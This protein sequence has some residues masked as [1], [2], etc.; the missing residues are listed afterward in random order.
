MKKKLVISLICTCIVQLSVIA[1]PNVDAGIRNQAGTMNVHDLNTLKKYKLEQQTTKDYKRF[2]EQKEKEELLKEEEKEQKQSK[3]NKKVIKARAEEYA[4][5]GVYVEN[6][7]V[8]PSEILTTDEIENI[9]SGY[10]ETNITFE[11]L[12]KI[13]DEINKLYFK[14]GFVTASAYIPEQTI[15]N[16]L[17]K[18]T[19]AE[20]RVGNISITD[21]KW[22]RKKYINDRLNIKE[23][24]IF[25]IS[26]LE[27]SL[28]LFNRYNDNVKLKG[29]LVPGEEKLLTTDVKI[30]AIEKSPFHLM[31]LMDNAGRTT[32]GKYRGGFILQND[33]LFGMRDKLTLGTYVN[34]YSVTPFADYNIPVN[35]KDGRIG[36]SFSSGYTKIGHG[37]FKMFNIRS[38]SYNY[39]L[40]FTQPIIRKPWMEL[41]STSSLNYKQ[42]ST[43]FDGYDLYTDKIS[44]AQTGLSFRYDT[45]RG[46]WYLNQNVS[47]AAPLFQ[48]QS[49]Y[50]KIDGN[51]LRLHDFGHGVVG[52]IRG[53]YQVIPKDV[54]PYLDQF[55]AGGL[56]TVRGYSEG[57][58][59]GR[60]G[61]LVSS[62]ILFPIAP[63]TIK[64]KDK[65]KEIPFLGN[66]L[67]G[68][69]F[70]DHAGVFPYKGTGLGSQGY[71]YNDFL[72]SVGMG[73]R[74]S[75]PGNISLRLAW[76][77]PLMRN[78][79]E[80]VNKL[81]RF[82]FEMCITPDF[83]A[84]VKL[85]RPKKGIENVKNDDIKLAQSTPAQKKAT[86]IKSLK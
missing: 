6:I 48:K 25:N 30:Q 13:I 67:K 73:L 45:A 58:L 34:K 65:T 4:T 63:R 7:E 40:Y 14:N 10:K 82:H 20:G 76:G 81:G 38:R 26:K 27:E 35:K 33:S 42:A 28:V 15:E 12:K 50:V 72:I 79:Y 49:N 75:L 31:C 84:M 85:R 44:S 62:E 23:G 11:Q 21:N 37:P 71:N 2:Q 56:A 36:A 3:K 59:I 55:L 60:N 19:L 68:F 9:L 78:K 1:V 29:N 24:E 53:C 22:T 86:V 32:I 8:S 43:S 69:A 52:Q 18:I 66:Y 74:I 17:I 70:A 83:D 47:Y 80:E 54:V 5:K 51:F 77:F 16:N 41:S 46:I 57:L 64:S 61:Y 39:S